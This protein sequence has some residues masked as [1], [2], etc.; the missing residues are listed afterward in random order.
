VEE[1]RLERSEYG[2]WPTS[3]GWFVVNVRDAAWTASEAF[4]EACIFESDKVS[5]PDVGYTLLVFRPGQPS[6]LY[7]REANAEDFLVLAGECLLLVEGAER[8][9]RAWDFVHCPAGTD[10]IFVATGHGPCV[11]FMAG[12]RTGWPEKGIVYPRSQ[13]ALRHG[14]GVERETAV[15]AEAYAPFP[16]WRPGRLDDSGWL[17]F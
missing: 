11:I 2:L 4:G 6:G 3:E 17:P 10:H 8:Q 14:A 7:H 12:A 9:L 1:A 5:F 16:P 15:P 13:T